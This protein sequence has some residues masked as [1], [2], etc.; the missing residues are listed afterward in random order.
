M[1]MSDGADLEGVNPRPFLPSLKDSQRVLA[2][3]LIWFVLQVGLIAVVV[4][5]MTS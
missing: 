5:V 1:T 3:S 2:V 4:W